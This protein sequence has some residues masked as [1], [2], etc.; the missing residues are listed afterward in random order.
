MLR[1][2]VDDTELLL[3]ASSLTGALSV[4][5]KFINYKLSNRSHELI[6]VNGLY[7]SHANIPSPV[8]Y[9]SEFHFDQEAVPDSNISRISPTDTSLEIKN[10]DPA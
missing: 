9:D 8:N 5:T 7:D 6:G 2:K 1:A 3:N 10:N 4:Y